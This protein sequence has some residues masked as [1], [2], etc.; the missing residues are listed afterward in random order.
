MSQSDAS[1]QK[2][3]RLI[4]ALVA[5]AIL[6][7]FVF[8]VPGDHV[9]DGAYERWQIPDNYDGSGCA[10]LTPAWQGILPWNQDTEMICLGMCKD[11]PFWTP[12]D[13]AP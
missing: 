9:C 3:S 10:K 13:P 11:I 8:A 6:I 1:S 2:D 7:A 12:D 5:I 4:S